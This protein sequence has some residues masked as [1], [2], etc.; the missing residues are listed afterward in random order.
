MQLP[1][2]IGPAKVNG[3]ARRFAGA[4]GAQR[5][6]SQG[7]P[8]PRPEPLAA[9]TP[10]PEPAARHPR[11]LFPRDPEEAF[12]AQC[13]MS[14]RETA[15]WIHR[16]HIQ[17]V[18]GRGS[19]DSPPGRGFRA[20]NLGVRRYLGE[21]SALS[22]ASKN[23]AST[24]HC[25]LV[26]QVARHR[27]VAVPKDFNATSAEARRKPALLLR[28]TASAPYE[29]GHRELKSELCL[30]WRQGE[31]RD[32][33]HEKVAI[34]TEDGLEVLWLYRYPAMFSRAHCRQQ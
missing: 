24:R 18:D 6:P 16:H 2:G 13:R 27:R 19:P 34:R 1:A 7:T 15:V 29:V 25:S 32:C 28:N 4:S 5:R 11:A 9:Q 26:L 22:V 30:T 20:G 17:R 3:T 14:R 23:G 31:S 10:L 21:S 12:E 8:P 33:A